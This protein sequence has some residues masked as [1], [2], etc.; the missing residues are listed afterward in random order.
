MKG[1][2]IFDHIQLAQELI[3]DLDRKCRG[4]NV[5]FK[6]DML[7]AYDRMEWHFLF[8]VLK[9]FGFSERFVDLIRRSLDNNWFTTIINGKQAGF[10]KAI[11]GLKQGDPLSPSLFIIAQEVFSGGAS[12]LFNQRLCQRYATLGKGLPPSHLFFADD[13]LLFC[14][15]DKSSVHHLMEFMVKYEE[16][17]GQ[18]M[19]RNK[20]KYIWR[21]P[22]LNSEMIE[23]STG[24]SRAS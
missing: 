7:K 9:K 2:D 8:V 3:N 12:A 5:V 15:G 24:F 18:R 1:R 21:K 17:S 23:Q 6:L 10:F 4:G 11:R 22:S 13:A 14:R 20:C 19:G 16:S